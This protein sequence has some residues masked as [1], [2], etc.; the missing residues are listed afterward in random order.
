MQDAVE[1]T[2]DSSGNSHLTF[3][4]IV[5]LEGNQITRPASRAP[6]SD[7]PRLLHFVVTSASPAN[8]RVERA[9][10]LEVPEDCGH[11]DDLIFQDLQSDE[12]LEARVTELIPV[13]SAALQMRVSMAVER[14]LGEAFAEMHSRAAETLRSRGY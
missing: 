1:K 6:I 11:E 4:A 14:I 3:T 8:A 13:L 12:V 2:K 10:G 5:K 9:F 7:G